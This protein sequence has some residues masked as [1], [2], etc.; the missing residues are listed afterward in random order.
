MSEVGTAML[1]LGAVTFAYLAIVF[2]VWRARRGPSVPFS[3]SSLSS[4][5]L[6]RWPTRSPG[7][8]S[9]GEKPPRLPRRNPALDAPTEISAARLA[10]IS[11]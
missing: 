10:R 2:F 6:L 11:G 5:R 3:L 8:R 1:T 9:A 4:F 7:S